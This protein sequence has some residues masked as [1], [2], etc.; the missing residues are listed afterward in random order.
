MAYGTCP[1]TAE[2]VSGVVVFVPGA[3]LVG[4]DIPPDRVVVAPE[5]LGEEVGA[6]SSW[7]S[8]LAWVRAVLASRSTVMTSPA[9]FCQVGCSSSTPVQWQ[10]R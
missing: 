4:D 5:Q 8:V 6:S 10:I 2:S 3:V 1:F 7:P 9:H